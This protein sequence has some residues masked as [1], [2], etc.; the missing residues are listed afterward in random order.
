MLIH[1]RHWLFPL[2]ISIFFITQ[3]REREREG[4]EREIELYFSTVKILAHR[5][6]DISAVAVYRNTERRER[7]RE[8]GRERE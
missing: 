3:E 1:E 6:T 7:K 2:N 4:G 5:S 8:G